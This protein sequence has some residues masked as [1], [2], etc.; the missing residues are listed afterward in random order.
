MDRDL[1]LHQLDAIEAEL[2]DVEHA[3]RRLDEGTYGTCE[4]CGAPIEAARLE[5]LPAT[6]ICGKHAEA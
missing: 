6:R 1:D 3:L 5:A 4:R 2:T